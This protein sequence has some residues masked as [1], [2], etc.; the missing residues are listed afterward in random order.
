MDHHVGGGAPA[1]PLSL[2]LLRLIAFA[3]WTRLGGGRAHW[4][5]RGLCLPGAPAPLKVRRAHF[6]TRPRCPSRAASRGVGAQRV[7]PGARRARNPSR[8]AEARRGPPFRR[9]AFD[10]RGQAARRRP[11]RVGRLRR[12]SRAACTRTPSS[13]ASSRRGG[14]STGARTSIRTTSSAARRCSSRASKATSLRRR[15]GRVTKRHGVS[16]AFLNVRAKFWKIFGRA[17]RAGDAP[18]RPRRHRRPVEPG[19]REPV[20]LPPAR[21]GSAATPRTVGTPRMDRG[22]A[23]AANLSGDT[24][25]APGTS[26]AGTAT[27]RPAERTS[28]PVGP[29]ASRRPWRRTAPV[30]IR[31]RSKRIVVFA[32]RGGR[33]QVDTI[34][35]CLDRGARVD[36]AEHYGRTP[37]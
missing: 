24:S 37:L 8:L 25:H 4:R 17:Y 9:S 34:K 32:E 18:P 28:T 31:R 30:V 1:L 35:L 13:A 26:P 3:A 14:A 22:D 19:R 33:P 7:A 16:G 5:L 2:K 10:G 11:R 27:S 15:S 21:N 23:A 29:R 36:L 12:W 20:V 6:P